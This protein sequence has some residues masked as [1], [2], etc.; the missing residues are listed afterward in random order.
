MIVESVGSLLPATWPILH[1]H[2]Y[3]FAEEGSSVG[4]WSLH[5]PTDISSTVVLCNWFPR[6]LVAH[7]DPVDISWFILGRIPRAETSAGL[8]A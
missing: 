5:E 4:A 2:V 6:I 1:A 3:R 7:V 8:N